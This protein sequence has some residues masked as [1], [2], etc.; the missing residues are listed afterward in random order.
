MD[1]FDGQAMNLD[2][3]PGIVQSAWRYKWLVAIA[4]LVGALLG[5]A[6]EAR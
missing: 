6:W 2:E 4:A 1:T 5:Y 3:G